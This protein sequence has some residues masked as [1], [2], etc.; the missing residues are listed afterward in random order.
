M[1][2]NLTKK[3]VLGC[4]GGLLTALVIYIGVQNTIKNSNNVNSQVLLAEETDATQATI[5][6]TVTPVPEVISAIGNGSPLIDTSLA[7]NAP[8]PTAIP[9]DKDAE[10]MSNKYKYFDTTYVDKGTLS[11]WIMETGKDVPVC[12]TAEE[13]EAVL[14]RFYGN[15]VNLYN[16][17][18]MSLTKDRINGKE[19]GIKYI[20]QMDGPIV[21]WYYLTDITTIYEYDCA[22]D[23]ALLSFNEEEYFILDTEY[24]LYVQAYP[25]TLECDETGDE[26]LEEIFDVNSDSYGNI[27]EK[28]DKVSY[29]SGYRSYGGIVTAVEE[30]LCTV[31]WQVQKD[32]LYPKWAMIEGVG[33]TLSHL[34]IGVPS[35]TDTY[36]INLLTLEDPFAW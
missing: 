16:K 36:Q 32:D 15:Y 22:E 2:K 5:I 10:I 18:T 25:E 11:D 23:W 29:S 9:V 24:D 6:P 21:Y 33:N 14:S 34:L 1:M 17:S 7:T 19:Y 12:Q 8:V 27:V 31:N 30:G 13:C 4:I 26:E 3:V 28:G 35:N 20:Y